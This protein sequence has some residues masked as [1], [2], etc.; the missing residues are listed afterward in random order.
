MKKSE[1]T[2]Q[3]IIERAAD[4]FN[5]KG[6]AG[7]TIDDILKA[8]KIAKGCLYGHFESKDQ[9]ALASA[10]YLLN[11]LTAHTLSLIQNQK[12]AAGKLIAFMEVNPNP[13]HN[14]FIHGGCPI[15]NFGVE[16]DDTNQA[17]REK[18]Q[19]VIKLTTKAL[20]SIIKDGIKS[21]EIS[22]EMIPE[23]F[24]LKMFATIEGATMMSRVMNSPIPM[25]N[26]IKGFKS[27]LGR[28]RIAT[29]KPR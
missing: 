17:I 23:E 27:E 4:I 1:R 6:V 16:A 18:V 3:F 9:L 5:E 15:M 10:E 13:L 26:A 8:A 21:G 19:H 14:T 25:K 2:K 29:V 22:S 20:V 11:K 24:A 12:T 7:T 28:F